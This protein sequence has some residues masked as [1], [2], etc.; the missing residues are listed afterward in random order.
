[1]AGAERAFA[2][3]SAAMNAARRQSA[4]ESERG[5]L[6]YDMRKDERDRAD[7]SAQSAARLDSMK[8]QGEQALKEAEYYRKAADDQKLTRKS[9][10]EALTGP[11]AAF[12]PE[13]EKASLRMQIAEVDKMIAGYNE[14]ANKALMG[15]RYQRYQY[16]EAHDTYGV[17]EYWDGNSIKQ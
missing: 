4:L 12:M 17:P 8:Y 15:S 16:G 5:L 1:V 14:A 7:E 3:Q 6:E 2:Q 11:D 9:L 13:E 10:Q